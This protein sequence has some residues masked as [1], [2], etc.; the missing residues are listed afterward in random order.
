VPSGNEAARR[1]PGGCSPAPSS[2]Y[3]DS[4]V[5]DV[6]ERAA[7]PPDRAMARNDDLARNDDHGRKSQEAPPDTGAND[8]D[9]RGWRK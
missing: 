2:V 4:F 8:Q 9:Q 1:C 7:R 5:L 3:T 6:T